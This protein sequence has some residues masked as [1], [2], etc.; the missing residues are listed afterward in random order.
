MKKNQYVS[1]LHIEFMFKS[2]SPLAYE[3]RDGAAP[4]AGSL[5][6]CL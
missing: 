6:I 4:S 5:D 1:E 2:W 3:L